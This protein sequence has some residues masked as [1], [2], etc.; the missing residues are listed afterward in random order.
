MVT[1]FPWSVL[2]RTRWA[3]RDKKKNEFHWL[4]ETNG[5]LNKF[6]AARWCFGECCE[7]CNWCRL[8]SHWCRLRVQKRGRSW[9]CYS[10]ENRRKCGDSQWNVHHDQSTSVTQSNCSKN[11]RLNHIF[12]F[13]LVST[14]SCGIRSTS[15]NASRRRVVCHWTIWNWITLIC[16]LFIGRSVFRMSA[17]PS[18]FPK[19]V[20]ERI[21]WGAY[22]AIAN[23][24][25]RQTNENIPHLLLSI[26][27]VDFVDTWR[28][29][30]ALVE[31]G[32]VRSIGV[33][34]FNS[35]Q[36]GRLLSAST[37]KPVM[38]Q[39]EVSPT[40]NQRKLIKYCR[41]NGVE[42]T[43]YS[44]LGRPNFETKTPE[45]FF[46]E[47]VNAIGKKY[48]KSTAQVVLKYLVSCHR[49]CW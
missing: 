22:T 28:A 3:L 37:I 8:S 21:W 13:F 36:L 48:G 18:C 47:E 45:Y 31:K 7:R 39:V 20:T 2:E 30:E 16:I 42:V 6:V 29:M 25:A 5:L 19:T 1:R 4:T 46:D 26:S 27:D 14:R 33:S 11:D 44:P 41:D 49:R 34:N 10:T 24:G 23:T 32:L 43:A 17:T 9:K 15:L 12:F 40:L 35:E 38:N